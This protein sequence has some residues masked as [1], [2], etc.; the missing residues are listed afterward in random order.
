MTDQD[1]ELMA[2]RDYLGVPDGAR[3]PITKELVAF[4]A[5]Q[6]RDAKIEV[7]KDW[8][9]TSVSH[10]DPPPPCRG[11]CE[12]CA[13]EAEISRLEKERDAADRT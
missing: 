12:R 9:E 2:V 3:G 8:A 10:D 13:L 5:A 1:I 7:L 11:R 6:R 4:V